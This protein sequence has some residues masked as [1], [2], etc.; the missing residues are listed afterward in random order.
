MSLDMNTQS[1]IGLK[2]QLIKN[3]A[4][5]SKQSSDT[6]LNSFNAL[7]ADIV[8]RQT[9]SK[10]SSLMMSSSSLELGGG[11]D[12]DGQGGIGASFLSH[13][14]QS[15][16]QQMQTQQYWEANFAGQGAIKAA[17]STGQSQYVSLGKMTGQAQNAVKVQTSASQGQQDYEALIKEA[18][19]R[20]GVDANLVKAVVTAE[21]DFNPTVV[22]QAGA[23]GLMQL[24]PGTAQDMGVDDVFDP[25]QNIEG[26]TKYLSMM[27]QRFDG[28]ESKALAAYNWGPG[29]VEN[30]G[31]YPAETR[32]YLKKVSAYKD[33]YAKGFTSNA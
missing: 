25:A 12:S 32:N 19:E 14:M 30:G 17:N 21:S 22:S 11:I 2:N 1:L 5:A 3:Q 26:G 4:A 16:V 13:M 31:S 20:H 33:L 24:M 28:D 27:L 18:A 29:N 8:Q 15:A 6:K 7:C 10:L 9:L 23:Q